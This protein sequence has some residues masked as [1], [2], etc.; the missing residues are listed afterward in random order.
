MIYGVILAGGKG[1]RVKGYELPKQFVK[2]SGKPLIMHSVLKMARAQVI[3]TVIV[4]VPSEYLGHARDV[5]SEYSD[6]TCNSFKKITVIAGGDDRESSIVKAIEHIGKGDAFRDDVFVTH[7]ACRPFFDEEMIAKTVDAIATFDAVT[8][9]LPCA[10]T[11][12]SGSNGLLTANMD[13]SMLYTVQ[14]PQTFRPHEYLKL[15]EEGK[16]NASHESSCENAEFTDVTGRYI[17]ANKKV[18]VVS[19]S[20]LNFKITYA[21]DFALAEAYLALT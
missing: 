17:Q 21:E 6:D 10:D 5:I 7:D 15:I 14:T 8:A 20:R 9:A 1:S 4:V 16:D 18:A 13:R 19:G 3:D 11:I 12:A 2:L